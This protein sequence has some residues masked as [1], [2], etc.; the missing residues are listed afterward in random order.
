M[1][2]W[3]EDSK[4]IGMVY[5]Q[6]QKEHKKGFGIALQPSLVHN[7]GHVAISSMNMNWSVPE[8][9]FV[10]WISR[11]PL[12]ALKRFCIQNA[13]M[14]FSFQEK[15]TIWK[16]DTWLTIYYA[17][18]Q[19]NS[20]WDNLKVFWRGAEKCWKY[21][22]QNWPFFANSEGPICLSGTPWMNF[23]K[24]LRKVGF[25]FSKKIKSKN[26]HPRF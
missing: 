4:L 2:R 11:P 21:N 3:W 6:A 16:L 19:S 14:D 8:P 18:T 17:K 22:T 7:T 13:C 23:K 25:C 24:H 15:K 10:F 1:K 5:E 12:I 26:T 9:H 20:F